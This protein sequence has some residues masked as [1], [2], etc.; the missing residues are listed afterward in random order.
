MVSCGRITLNNLQ[1]I[2]E[3]WIN[4]V[5]IL[6]EVNTVLVRAADDSSLASAN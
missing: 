5:L 2:C 3:R 4:G 6:L 1:I